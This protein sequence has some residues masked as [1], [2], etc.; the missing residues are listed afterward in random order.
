MMKFSSG[1]DTFYYLVPPAYMVF[2]NTLAVGVVNGSNPLLIITPFFTTKQIRQSNPLASASNNI[3][4][5]VR[6]NCDVAADSII[7]VSGLLGA[8]TAS[9]SI[10]LNRN[11]SLYVQNPAPWT[12]LNGTI[13]F[14]VSN[15]MHSVSTFEARFELQNN[16]NSQISQSISISALFKAGEFDSPVSPSEMV[17]QYNDVLGIQNGSSPMLTLLPE[18]SI[19]MIGQSNPLVSAS[20]NI[21]VTIQANCDISFGSIITFQ[22]ITGAQ[23]SAISIRNLSFPSYMITSTAELNQSDGSFNLTVTEKLLNTNSYVFSFEIRNGQSGQSPPEVA[24]GAV[25]ESGNFDST[26][27]FG[28]M[29]VPNEER[30]SVVNGSNPLLLIVPIFTVNNIGQSNPLALASNNITITLR[31]NCDIAAGSTITIFNLIGSAPG[32]EST[33]TL[34][35]NPIGSFDP[36]G[37]WN[38]STGSF[39]FSF[40]GTTKTKGTSAPIP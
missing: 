35:S 27:N 29:M 2:P 12:Q 1:A 22:G 32:A 11:M 21:T 7:S 33:L 38:W 6:A 15:V 14:T 5:L 4:L 28:A 31:A 24:I 19:K 30:L 20:N 3:T 16:R 39:C 34:R 17:V 40:R 23:W 36:S 18:F 10:A 8:Q 9:G 25:I 26:I 13:I 37:S